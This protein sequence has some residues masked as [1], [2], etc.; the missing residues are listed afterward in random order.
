MPRLDRSG[1]ERVFGPVPSRRLGRSLG[2]DLVPRKTCSFDCVYCQVGRTTRRTVAR[3]VLAPR[4]EAIKELRNRLQ[5]GAEA[6]VITLAGSGEPTLHAELG[7][8]I[9]DIK[10]ISDLPVAVLTNGSLLFDRGVRADCAKADLVLPSLDAG[11]EATFQAVNR[12]EP[13]LTLARV[14]DGLVAFRREFDGPIWLEVFLVEGV[15]AS[16]EQVRKIGEWVETI[17][18]DKVHLN[19]AVRPTAE[20]AVCR[21]PEGRMDT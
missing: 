7:A 15:N 13:S 8:V 9:D 17:R 5:E 6:D 18:P 10:A 20:T 21:V 12:P 4:A 2:V 19:T 11:D 16:R 1:S 3:S 14:A